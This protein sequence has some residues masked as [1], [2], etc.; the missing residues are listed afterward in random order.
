MSD[1]VERIKALRHNGLFIAITVG[2]LIRLLFIPFSLEYDT[3]FWAVVIRNIESGNGLYQMEGY[4]YT[5]VWGYILSL[6]AGIQNAFFDAGDSSTAIYELISYSTSDL[7]AYTHMASS[8]VSLLILKVILWACDLLLAFT[9]YQLVEERT[10]DKRKAI[11]AF[12]L[13]F[14]CPHVIGSSSMVVMPDTIS[15]LFTMLTILLLKHDRYFLAGVCYSFAVWIKFFPIAIILVLLC[16][17]YVGAKGEGKLAA[18]RIA[19]SIAGFILASVITFLPS[20]MEGT[21]PR[22]LAFLT[23]RLVEIVKFGFFSILLA[24]L[25]ALLAIGVA[26]VIARHMLNAREGLEDRMM[27]Y[28]MILLCICM[29][30]YT[31]MQYLV[32]LIP[33]LVYCVMVVDNRYKYIWIAL[34]VAGTILTLMLNTNVVALNSIIAYTGLISA[35]SVLPVFEFINR[36][37]FFNFSIVDIFCSTGNNIQKITLI[38][39][40]PAFILRRMIAS[41]RVPRWHHER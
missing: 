11:I 7:Y 12:V 34:A 5:P 35:D 40:I 1:L 28:S 24:V 30:L 17:I 23:D 9:V 22:S 14:V 8:I 32:T 2:I 37:I 10:G 31:N 18:K 3:N 26:V 41:G 16:Y 39:I 27:E 20:Y 25:L 33:F 36:E 15:A 29:L 13:V 19:L 4:Y 21:L 6:V 38:C